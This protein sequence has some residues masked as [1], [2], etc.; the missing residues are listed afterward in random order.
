MPLHRLIRRAVCAGV[1]VAL[2]TAAAGAQ[3][4]QDTRTLTLQ[5]AIALAQRSGLQAGAARSTRDAARSRDQLFYTQYLPT[6]SIGGAV[7]TYNRSIQGVT[8]PD[9]STKYI[10]VQQTTGFLTANVVQRLPWTNTTFNFSSSLSQVQVSGATGFKTWSSTPFQVGITQPI[11][12]ANSQLWDRAQ[13][14]LRTTSAERHYLEAR[15]DVAIAV[16]NAFFDLNTAAV[17]LKNLEFNVATNDTLYT[18]N[19]GRFEVGKIGEN[20]LLQSELALLRARSA[21]DDGKVTY[22]RALSS[23]RLALNLPQGTPVAIAAST[24]VP[25]FDADTAVAVQQAR[26]NA[27]AMSDAE[28]SE[29]SA[30]RAVS[31]ARWNAGAGGTLS[32]SYGYNATASRAPDVYKNLLDAQQLQLQVSLPVFQ[33][34]AHAAQVQAAT[35]DREAAKNNATVARQQLEQAAYFAALGLGQARR[36]LALAAKADTVAAKRFDVA[37]NRYGV[38]KILIDNLFIAQQEKDQALA[39]FV[40]A[41]RAY[42]IAYF[43]LRRTTLYDFEAGSPI[44]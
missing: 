39:A 22:D 36:S 9:G 2:C 12:R 26:R 20:D 43:Q 7:P 42:W 40:Q 28:L 25:S 24:V 11:F 21:R 34:G 35:A 19:K 4:P 23:F 1:V 37:Y 14:D 41:Q 8:Q 5:E 27:S 33:W 15:E 18:L 13:E 16:T 10:P 32:A 44:R 6:L 3:Q 29:V 17:T 31:E 38:S 30:N